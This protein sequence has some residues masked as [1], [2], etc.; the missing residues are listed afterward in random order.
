VLYIRVQFRTL[1]QSAK[2]GKLMMKTT[3]IAGAVAAAL[4]SGVAMA[5]TPAPAAPASPHTITG[6]VGIFSQ[7]IFR[8]LKQTNGEPAIQGGFDY[9]HSSGLYAGTWASNV[10]WLQDSGAYISGGSAELDFYGGIKGTFG[11]SDFSWDVGTLYYWYPGDPN[12][13]ANPQNPKA[14]T[15]EIYGALG[16]KWITAKFS[17]VVSNKA[18][19]VLDAGGTYYFDLGAAVPLGESGFTIDAHYGYQKFTGQDPRLLG[20]ASND[21]ACS[22]DDWKLGI[23]YTLPKD[24][25]VGAYYTDT[26]SANTLCYGTPFDVPAGAYPKNIAKGTGTVYIKKTF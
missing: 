22:Y 10:S 18:F 3:M 20:V 7:Y 11:K 5:Q 13:I 24:F 25:V 21:A 23:S 6:N 17:Y 4:G 1:R 16:W 26:S 8:G 9:S 2:K 12:T 15:W 14:D 19:G